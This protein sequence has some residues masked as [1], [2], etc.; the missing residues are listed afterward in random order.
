[1]CLLFPLLFL[2]LKNILIFRDSPPPPPPAFSLPSD[3]GGSE[4]R[5]RGAPWGHG[6]RLLTPRHPAG[7][8]QTEGDAEQH[9][10]ELIKISCSAVGTRGNQLLEMFDRSLKDLLICCPPKTGANVNAAASE[11]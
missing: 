5:H 1:M 4:E 8:S 3:S 10:E 9:E 7:T 11:T 6:C 2:L